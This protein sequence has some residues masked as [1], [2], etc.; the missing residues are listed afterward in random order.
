MNYLFSTYPEFQLC[1][2][3][4]TKDHSACKPTH[5]AWLNFLL[6]LRVAEPQPQQNKLRAITLRG[7]V[8]QAVVESL[9]VVL[10][11]DFRFDP[12]VHVH[13]TLHWRACHNV[14]WSYDIDDSTEHEHTVSGP[15][16][17]G[18]TSQAIPTGSAWVPPE[19]LLF[20][21]S[22][23]FGVDQFYANELEKEMEWIPQDLYHKLVEHQPDR[24]LHNF[25]WLSLAYR[26]AEYLLERNEPAREKLMPIL[27]QSCKTA[28]ARHTLICTCK[29][30]S[31]IARRMLIQE[32]NYQL[33]MLQVVARWPNFRLHYRIIPTNNQADAA[34]EGWILPQQLRCFAYQEEPFWSLTK[35]LAR[36]GPEQAIGL[37]PPEQ[38]PHRNVCRWLLQYCGRINEREGYFLFGTYMN[39]AWQVQLT[40]YL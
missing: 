33:F 2:Y 27:Q 26:M 14:G 7:C 32:V 12:F 24:R 30:W 34:E 37:N 31:I 36:H 39:V 16:R 4:F 1:F 13:S 10:P 20:F 38:N 40:F 8:Q 23:I 11:K 18:L 35:L 19:N 29:V 17:L 25:P 21:A 6:Y 3:P 15:I 9:E 22:M 28:D 5:H